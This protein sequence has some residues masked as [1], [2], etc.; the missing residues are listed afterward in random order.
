MQSPSTVTH[1]YLGASGQSPTL[2]LTSWVTLSLPSHPSIL[3]LLTYARE[4]GTDGVLLL[5]LT[6]CEL[7]SREKG[8]SQADSQSRGFGRLTDARIAAGEG[9]I[10][11]HQVSVVPLVGQHLLHL[12]S[13]LPFPHLGLSGRLTLA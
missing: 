4:G 2:L 7:K 11:G 5:V 13:P 12:P 3:G 9:P 6:V 8:S 10:L 1:L